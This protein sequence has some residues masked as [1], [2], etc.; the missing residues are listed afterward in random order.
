M[1]SISCY[2]Q[3]YSFDDFNRLIEIDY[4]NG[5]KI[6]YTYDIYGN[7]TQELVTGSC[8]A[9]G[10]SEEHI[11]DFEH[12]IAPWFQVFQ[13]NANWTLY[14]GN[15]TSSNT[16]PTTASHGHQYLYTEA[17]GGNTGLIHTLESPCFDISGMSNPELTLDY[18]MYG[19]TIASLD[20]IIST[21]G[22]SSWTNLLSQNGDQGNVWHEANLN[23]TPFKNND[24][25]IRIFAY[26]GTTW[27]SDIAIDH[28]RI[29]EK[30]CVQNLVLTAA[31]DQ[32]YESSQTITTSG[33]VPINSGQNTEFKS[34]A[35]FLKPGMHAQSGSVFRADIDPCAN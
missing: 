21:D 14:E 23:L 33:S 7:R 4:G 2:A 5:D 28:I 12:G 31:I 34:Q 16:G 11:M 19:A 27:Q 30:E 8:I 13:D 29:K 10:T 18:H 20:V 15:T 22:G 1:I 6:Q 9:L 3:N 32:L 35:I 26:T 25:I 24:I 17:S